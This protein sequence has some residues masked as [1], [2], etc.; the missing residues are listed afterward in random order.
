MRK[1]RIPTVISLSIAILVVVSS[2][3][4]YAQVAGNTVSRGLSM[5]HA[6]RGTSMMGSFN[7]YSTGSE[8]FA[9]NV[10]RTSRDPLA[11][12][13]TVNM[14]TP[15]SGSAGVGGSRTGSRPRNTDL[16]RPVINTGIIRSVRPTM[17]NNMMSQRPNMITLGNLPRSRIFSVEREIGP[18]RPVRVKTTPFTIKPQHLQQQLYR[19]GLFGGKLMIAQKKS[20]IHR[21]ALTHNLLSSKKT[22][23]IE[24]PTIFE[25]GQKIQNEKRT[26][27]SIFNIR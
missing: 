23:N 12:R 20:I 24:R 13:S 22:L 19:A 21:D 3:T 7:R 2:D 14:Q 15:M 27:K 1:S 25:I 18:L 6:A 10:R 17:F 16:L 8:R 11:V 4:I 5:P 26:P 9:P